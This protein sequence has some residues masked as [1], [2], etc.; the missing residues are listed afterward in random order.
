MKKLITILLVS[1]FIFPNLAHAR[2]A[3]RK[4][5]SGLKTS[6]ASIKST[7]GTIFGIEYTA[8]SAGGQVTVYD[9]AGGGGTIGADSPTELVEVK[10]ATQNDSEYISF[11]PEGLNTNEGI[12]LWL[13]Y[14]E[15]II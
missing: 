7:P 4:L 3:N 13:N 14:A 15:A 2:N 10:E 9:H 8:T 11:G 5:S 1:L 12:Y 6:S